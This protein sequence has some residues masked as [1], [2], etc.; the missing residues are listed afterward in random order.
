MP[1]TSVLQKLFRL[2]SVEAVEGEDEHGGFEWNQHA[3]IM[4]AVVIV[5]ISA[6]VVYWLLA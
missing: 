1:L 5:I 6:F 4:L 2:P 3:R